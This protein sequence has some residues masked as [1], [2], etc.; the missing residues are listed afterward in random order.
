MKSLYTLVEELNQ[1]KYFLGFLIIFLNISSKFITIQLNEY[2]EKI[3]RET[4]GHQLLVFAICFIGTRDI[5][6]ALAMSAIFIL[7]NDYLLNNKSVLCI[8][9]KK[10]HNHMKMAIDTNN[11]DY[12]DDNEIKRAV[13][14]LNKAN[15]QKKK[16]RNAK[17]TLHL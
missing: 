13:H 9:P 17:H 16:K 11:D 2:H 10:Y 1:S 3:L 5:L 15:K 12:I 7:L 6:V 14:I 8:I 4:V